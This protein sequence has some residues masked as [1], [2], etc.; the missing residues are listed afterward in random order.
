MEAEVREESQ[1]ETGDAALLVVRM[2]GGTRVWD[3]MPL[4]AGKGRRPTEEPPEGAQPTGELGH[5]SGLQSS[6]VN[7]C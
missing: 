6:R 4:E 5:T 7:L 1:R 2:E 3:V